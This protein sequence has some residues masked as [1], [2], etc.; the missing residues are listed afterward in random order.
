MPTNIKQ[1]TIFAIFMATLMSYFMIN[2]NKFLLGA[3]LN[4]N[5]FY[6][7]VKQYIVVL[8]IAVAFSVLF[9]NKGAKIIA[10]R[11]VEP[12]NTHPFKVKSAFTFAHVIFMAPLMSLVSSGIWSDMTLRDFLLTWP[13][14]ILQNAPFAFM[15]NIFIAAPIVGFIFRRIK[16]YI[17]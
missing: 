15:I 8:P 16:P 1:N 5:L 3:P 11:F 2:Y 12:G 13:I 14:K 17:N 7:P 4:R 6:F 10:L 9:V